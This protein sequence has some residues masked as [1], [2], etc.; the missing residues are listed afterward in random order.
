MWSADTGQRSVVPGSLD[1]LETAI[2]RGFFDSAEDALERA[3]DR[4]E[5]IEATEGDGPGGSPI[6]EYIQLAGERGKEKEKP[7]A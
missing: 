3:V 6:D 2:R 1:E 4:R 5:R 7:A